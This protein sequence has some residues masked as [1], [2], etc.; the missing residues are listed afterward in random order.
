MPSPS[1]D[2]SS[3]YTVIYLV[4]ESVK[5]T[6]ISDLANKASNHSHVVFITI[7]L[8]RYRPSFLLH[9]RGSPANLSSAYCS[10]YSTLP[11][12]TGSFSST[13]GPLNCTTYGDPEGC[14]FTTRIGIHAARLGTWSVQFQPLLG[15]AKDNSK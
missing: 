1:V 8:M 7:Q 10:P 4:S 11:I 12:T 6:L 15:Q 13:S 2:T 14:V 3:E 9:N 5:F